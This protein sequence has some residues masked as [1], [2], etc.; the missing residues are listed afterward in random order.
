MNS[1][2]SDILHEARALIARGDHVDADAFE[3]RVRST[4]GDAGVAQL[5]RLLAV[6]RAKRSLAAPPTA[7]PQSPTPRPRAA[8]YRA[9]PTVAGTLAVR[10]HGA[11]DAVVL[12]WEPRREVVR[13][14]ARIAERADA[15]AP[16]VDRETLT[17][18]G[19]RLELRLTDHP[20]RVSITG[21]AASG[22][23]VQHALVSGL[24]SANWTQQWQRR[25][26]A[27]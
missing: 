16:Y 10:A 1:E 18:D 13:W 21:R 17:L 23:V 8:V 19:P 6:A 26:T 20:Q 4:G 14:D 25:A 22:R 11:G 3:A 24:T 27:S 9:K 5:H 2:L 7:Q 12:E 15:R